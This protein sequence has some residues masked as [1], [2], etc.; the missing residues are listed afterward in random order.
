MPRRLGL[1]ALIVLAFAIGPS[2]ARSEEG[3]NYR[4][5]G[6][7]AGVGAVAALESFKNNADQDVDNA[8]GFNI[9]GGY[10]MTDTWS[11][12]LEFEMPGQFDF[13][14]NNTSV[15]RYHSTTSVDLY[16]TTINGK[17]HLNPGFLQRFLMNGRLQP[18]VIGG[19]GWILAATSGSSASAS[20]SDVVFRFGGGLDFYATPNVVLAFDGTYVVAPDAIQSRP[21]DYQ[22]ASLS[23]G[24]QYRY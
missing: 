20:S 24:V 16:V 15:P 22:Y 23:F 19:A 17:A 21:H 12:E 10:R 6:W 2:R 18:N 13:N 1:T 8:F 11:A 7:Y 4:R 14:G 5:T 9:R 3:P